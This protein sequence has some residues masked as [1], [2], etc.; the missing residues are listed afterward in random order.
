MTRSPAAAAP[1]GHG[2]PDATR[3]P[4]PMPPHLRT[5]LI[6]PVKWPTLQR[7]ERS[8]D[9]Q[10]DDL[11]S[12]VQLRLPGFDVAPGDPVSVQKPSRRA[13][14]KNPNRESSKVLDEP[15]LSLYAVRLA[16]RGA[17][18]RGLQAYS[19]ALRTILRVA[20]QISGHRVTFAQIF[21]DCDLL[22]QALVYDRHT[23]QQRQLSK[24]TLAQRRSAARSLASLLRPELEA[25]L[26]KDPHLVLDQALQRVAERV[27][28]GYR[29]SGGK[30]RR[31][32]G[33]TPTT[34]DIRAIL[35][36]VGHSHGYDGL[37]NRA[38]F[39]ILAETGARINALREL[40]GADCRLASSGNMRLFLHEKGK[41]EPREVEL[42]IK[43]TDQLLT[44]VDS[45]NQWARATRNMVRLNLGHPGPIWRNSGRGR[46]AYFDILATLRAACVASGIPEFTPHAFRRTFATDAASLLPRHIVAQAG[47]WRGLE[48]LDDHYIHPRAS[49]IWHKLA[50]LDVPNLPPSHVEI[51]SDST[52]FAL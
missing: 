10:V 3:Q 18:K 32:G 50:S 46:W 29:L 16:A 49:E 12:F 14:T 39:R 47:G 21:E 44:Y 51:S 41:R 2:I 43:A 13:S 45:F 26:G 28:T 31:R 24:W 5:A 7:N 36:E 15:M 48:R 34:E 1:S 42:S 4:P 30:P 8:D 6:Q 37:R 17:A 20:Q 52:N 33:H 23:T 19:Y 40:D 9:A 27:G 22:G 11:H 35:E 25:E 38:F